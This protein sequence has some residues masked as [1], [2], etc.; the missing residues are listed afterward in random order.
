MA[1]KAA[2]GPEPFGGVQPKKVPER[3]V[4]GIPTIYTYATC[5]FSL[6]VKSLLRSRGIDFSNVEV[7]P[8]KKT[9]LSGQIGQKFL[10][11]LTQMGL[12]LIIQMRFYTILMK[13]MA[14]NSLGREKIQSK[15]S[16]WIFQMIF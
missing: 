6:K 4:D 5:P 16:G 9:E 1:R 14:E 12:M 8:M 15:I 2:N 11:L 3:V 10:S 13:N 7:D